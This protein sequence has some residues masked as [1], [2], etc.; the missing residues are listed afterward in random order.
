MKANKI[1]LIAVTALLISG[2]S[3]LPVCIVSEYLFNTEFSAL[4]FSGVLITST[5]ISLYIWN[6]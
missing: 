4:H 6:K 1:K 5:L 2:A 3:M